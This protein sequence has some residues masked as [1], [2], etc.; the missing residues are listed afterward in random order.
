MAALRAVLSLAVV[1]LLAAPAPAQELLSDAKLGI[2][3]KAPDGFTKVP[4]QPGEEWIVVRWIS[5]CAY[6]QNDKS[7]FSVDHKPELNVIAFPSEKVKQ[8]VVEEKSGDIVYTQRASG[9][10]F[11]P[12]AYAPGAY[13]VKVGRDKPDAVEL[14]GID[15]A[16]DR[17]QAG[18]TPMSNQRAKPREQASRQAPHTRTEAGPET[19][20]CACGLLVA[21][22]AAPAGS[23]SRTPAAL[24]ALAGRPASPRRRSALS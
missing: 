9:A 14:R 3:L 6:F 12:P 24:Q 22:T 1:T 10:T 15:A 21:S 7:G 19:G 18:A 23:P 13:T 8:K 16:A 17:A 11:Q 5:D 2:K 20:L 4:L